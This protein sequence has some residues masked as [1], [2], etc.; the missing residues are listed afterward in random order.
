M[1]IA[2]IIGWPE[3]RQRVERHPHRAGRPQIATNMFH[4][5]WNMLRLCRDYDHR[6]GCHDRQEAGEITEEVIVEARAALDRLPGAERIYGAFVDQRLL[7][8]ARKEVVDMNVVLGG[9]AQVV[10]ATASTGRPP[11]LLNHGTVQVNR[12]QGWIQWGNYGCPDGP[13]PET[14]DREA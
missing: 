9:L 5:P 12:A 1:Q 4:N 14:G 7:A 8:K 13:E 3:I 11:Y 10:D 6:T 2:H